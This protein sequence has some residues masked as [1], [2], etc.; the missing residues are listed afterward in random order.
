MMDLNKEW[1]KQVLGD[2]GADEISD[3]TKIINDISK[4]AKNIKQ[5]SIGVSLTHKG[6]VGTSASL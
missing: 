4:R 1:L 6:A 2:L 3:F 5:S